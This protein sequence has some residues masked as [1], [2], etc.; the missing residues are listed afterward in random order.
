MMTFSLRP[1]SGSLFASIAASV[2]T[3]VVSWKDAADSHD[4]VANEAFVMPISSARAEAGCPPSVTTLRL[5]DS[6]SPRSTSWPVRKSVS[7]LSMMVTRL[8]IWRTITSMCL[9]WIDTPCERYTSWTCSTR[10]SCTA[11][12]PEHAKHRLGIDRTD[13]QL[14]GRPAHG[15]PR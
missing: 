15:R 14:A 12:W 5:V 7:P 6:N 2:S 13:S 8:S 3:R 10:C 11:R 1:S 9:S 4:S